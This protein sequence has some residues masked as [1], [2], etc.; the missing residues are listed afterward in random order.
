[1]DLRGPSRGA[2]SGPGLGPCLESIWCIHCNFC[3]L[4]LQLCVSKC[5]FGLFF[6]HRLQ[7]AFLPAFRPH[8]SLFSKTERILCGPSLVWVLRK[9]LDSKRIFHWN[10][11]IDSRAQVRWVIVN[12]PRQLF[13]G[14]EYH[15][16]AV[17]SVAHMHSCCGFRGSGATL[18]R[19]PWRWKCHCSR[20]CR[21]LGSVHV[22]FQP[23]LRDKDGL[24]DGAV[25]AKG[26][27]STLSVTPERNVSQGG[28]WKVDVALSTG[29]QK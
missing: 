23:G 15:G 28:D 7:L 16:G 10:G 17:W 6:F 3:W 27:H 2:G 22:D 5:K 20:C 14:I 26:R 13:C 19:L 8:L 9:L 18:W 21:F 25:S 29:R 1:M 24:K 12:F 4:L 11:T